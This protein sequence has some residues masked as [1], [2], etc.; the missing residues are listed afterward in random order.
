MKIDEARRREV[1]RELQAQPTA[2]YYFPND[3]RRPKYPL[4]WDQVQ[5]LIKLHPMTERQDDGTSKIVGDQQKYNA[6]KAEIGREMGWSESDLDR[7]VLKELNQQ[8]AQHRAEQVWRER[9]LELP[10]ERFQSI[11]DQHVRL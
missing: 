2:R 3:P 8:A 6:R 4:R 1:L 5:E 11:V 9:Q 7:R 10:R